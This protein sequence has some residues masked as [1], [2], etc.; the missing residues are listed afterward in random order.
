MWEILT[1]VHSA[2]VVAVLFAV[3]WYLIREKPFP[4][5][6]AFKQAQQFANNGKK[7]MRV[8]FGSQTGTAEGFAN[9]FAEEACLRYGFDAI[10]TDMVNFE[11]CAPTGTSSPANSTVCEEENK[12]VLSVRPAPLVSSCV[13]SK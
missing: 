3:Y 11:V 1:I 7:K 12:V 9:T 8:L 2:V 5:D 10:A 13:R 6:E 4:E